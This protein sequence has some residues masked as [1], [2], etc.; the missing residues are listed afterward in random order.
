MVPYKLPYYYFFVPSV[1]QI[2]RAENYA[3]KLEQM[4]ERLHFILWDCVGEGTQDSDRVELKRTVAER[5]R[6][7]RG[8]HLCFVWC[9]FHYRSRS[10]SRPCWRLPFFW[11]GWNKHVW[12]GQW[13]IL[14]FLRLSFL[15]L[16]LLL[17]SS[18]ISKASDATNFARQK[19]VIKQQANSRVATAMPDM[20]IFSPWLARH[21]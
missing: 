3:W 11:R 21:Q 1:V 15:L 20:M 5:G 9:A 2:S 19:I 16:L 17:P 7:S 18:H 6:C 4:L 10:P 13:R 8:G 12:L 14:L